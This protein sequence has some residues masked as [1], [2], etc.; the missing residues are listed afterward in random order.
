MP[1]DA[2]DTMEVIETASSAPP[3]KR[4]GICSHLKE[5]IV[6]TKAKVLIIISKGGRI[7]RNESSDSQV[8]GTREGECK[9]KYADQRAHQ[10]GQ[11]C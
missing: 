10:F 8:I 9:C 1:S 11:L 4:L 5:H 6:A 3:L 2:E 7:P